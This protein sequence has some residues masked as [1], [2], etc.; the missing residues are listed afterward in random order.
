MKAFSLIRIETLEKNFDNP[1]TEHTVLVEFFLQSISG[2]DSVLPPLSFLSSGQSFFLL[3]F[4]NALISLSF[5]F[6]GL[7]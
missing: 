3:R 4:Y 5:F 2:L 1:S 7:L 6:V